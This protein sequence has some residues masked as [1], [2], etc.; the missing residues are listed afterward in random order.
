VSA[1]AASSPVN[2]R[3]RPKTSQKQAPQ[4][5]LFWIFKYYSFM[6]IIYINI[7]QEDKLNI[8]NFKSI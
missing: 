8:E 6:L 3:G 5:M 7:I 2:K 1:A 4:G